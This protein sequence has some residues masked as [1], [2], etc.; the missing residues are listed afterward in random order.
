M[1]CLSTEQKRQQHSCGLITYWM[2]CSSLIE[3]WRA[4]DLFAETLQGP[5]EAEPSG[6]QQSAFASLMESVG[7]Q[8]LTVNTLTTTAN[9]AN[10]TKTA[11]LR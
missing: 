4:G 10:L 1:V 7:L 11:T 6:R 2:C 5:G 3:L 9:L 8:T